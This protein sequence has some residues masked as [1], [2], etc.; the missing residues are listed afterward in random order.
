MRVKVNKKVLLYQTIILLVLYSSFVPSSVY[1]PDQLPQSQSA[2]VFRIVFYNVENLFDTL[3]EP[4]RNDDFFTPGGE[5]RWDSFRLDKKLNN[6]HKALAAAGQWVPPSIIGLCEVENRYILEK[7]IG[8]TG[9][10]GSGYNIIHSNSPDSR[11]IDVA[12]LYKN[13]EFIVLDTFFKVINFPFDSLATTRDILYIKGIAG[14]TDTVHFFINHW[15]SRWGGQA[16][17][18]PYRKYTASV[19][20]SIVDSVSFVNPGASIVIMGDFN[21]EPEDISLR[22]C[23]GA[24]FDYNNLLPGE[25]YNL[26]YGEKKQGHGTIKFQGE[27]FLFDQFIVSGSLLDGEGGLQTCPLSTKILSAE[28]LLVPDYTWFGYKPF[29]TYEGFRY[30]GGF[31]DHLPVVLDLSR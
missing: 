3:N 24:G 19:L 25:L 20:R 31:S 26:S 2:G 30:T 8:N 28:F 7:L 9:L 29:R 15:T 16:A 4:G 12:V 13:D 21:D 6:L 23:L 17:T 18:E 22:E 5:R 1:E 11:G 14:G 10:S 27:W